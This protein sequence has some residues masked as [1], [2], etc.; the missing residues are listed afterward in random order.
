M[1]EAELRKALSTELGQGGDFIPPVMAST[2]FEYISL[3]AKARQLFTVVPMTKDKITYPVLGGGFNA[4]HIKEGRRAYLSQLAT[5]QV[6]LEVKKLMVATTI[7]EELLENAQVDFDGIIQ[8]QFAKALADG[9]DLAI[10]QGN[11]EHQATA[12]SPIEATESNWFELDPR[13]AYKGLIQ[14]ALEDPAPTPIDLAGGDLEAATYREIAKK[15]GKYAQDTSLL[16]TLMNPITAFD[17]LWAFPEFIEASKY[18]TV[19]TLWTGEIGRIYG[20]RQLT[21]G[22]IPLNMTI[23]LPVYNL[24]IGDRKQYKFGRDRDI[25]SEQI[26]ITTSMRACIGVPYPDAMILCQNVGA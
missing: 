2:Y 6:T 10:V 17:Q 4:Y 8:N 19:T 15:L 21:W 26:G 20:I 18:G 16:V 9:E 13:L 3:A 1:S 7:N 5:D 12:K 11:P 23:T 22:A 14:M 24:F 25:F